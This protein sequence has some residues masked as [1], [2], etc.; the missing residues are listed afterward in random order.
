MLG[1]LKNLLFGYVHDFPFQ[2]V[3]KLVFQFHILNKMLLYVLLCG[4]AQGGAGRCSVVRCVAVVY[5]AVL[6]LFLHGH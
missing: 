4:A 6:Q 3:F 1:D 5:C 2:E